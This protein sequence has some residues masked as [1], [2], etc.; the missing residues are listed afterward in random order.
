MQVPHFLKVLKR[1]LLSNRY[2]KWY[3]AKKECKAYKLSQERLKEGY[4]N[5]ST[6][7]KPNKKRV[8]VI[9]DNKKRSFGFA[10]RLRSIISIYKTSRELGLEFKILFTKPFKL[11][12]YLA[13]NEVDWE[14]E[15]E[16]L[17]YNLR[18]TDICC[19]EMRTGTDYEIRQNEK[20]FRKEFKKNYSEFHVRTNAAYSYNYNFAQ[21]FSTLFKPSPLLLDLIQSHIDILGREYISASFRFLELLGDFNEPNGSSVHLNEKEREML[22]K[23]NIE[24]IEKLHNR[25]PGIHILVNSDSSTFLEYADRLEYTYVVKGNIEHVDNATNLA[26]DAHDKTLTDFFMI[27]NAK[28]IYLFITGSMYNSNFPYAASKLYKKPFHIIHF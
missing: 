14:I 13:P 17:C 24:Q 27:A 19:L 6:A 9:Y 16:E 2:G 26:A 21:L 11:S 22:I 7:Q 10:D 28:E 12:R 3:I 5:N 1:K 15:P 20:W 4:T 25:H 18:D 23:R 8:V